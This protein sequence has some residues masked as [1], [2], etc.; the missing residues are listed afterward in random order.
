[1]IEVSRLHKRFGARQAIDTM[2]LTFPSATVTALVGLN[3]AGKT[4][5]L[6]LIAG[7]DRADGGAVRVC[8]RDPRSETRPTRLLGVHIDPD[9]MDPR[10]T[11]WR[12]LKW[13]ASLGGVGFERAEAMLAEVGLQAHR[14]ERV[15]ALSQ[16][17]RQRLAIAA[18]LLGDPAAVLFDEPLNGLDV[19]GIVWL[20]MLL[21][22]LADQGKTVVIASHVLGEVVRTADR[23]VILNG[24]KLAAAGDLA[25]IVPAG[26]D[27]RQWLEQTLL[28]QA[29]PRPACHRVGPS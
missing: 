26:A 28:A 29:D 20:R 6:R 23:L 5:L 2:T 4:T 10:H 11:V 16:G 19:S 25:E 24:G 13:L 22:R 9:A 3:G 21:R 8:G 27:P 17:A 18:A 1:M 12:H 7:L 14:S 15:A